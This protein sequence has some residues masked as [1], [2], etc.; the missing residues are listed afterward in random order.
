MGKSFPQL[1]LFSPSLHSFI[2]SFCSPLLV[3]SAQLPPSFIPSSLC[4]IVDE[5]PRRLWLVC[6]LVLQDLPLTLSLSSYSTAHGVVGHSFSS[7]A[8]LAANASLVS[9][10]RKSGRGISPCCHHF[11][12]LFHVLSVPPLSRSSSPY[13]ILY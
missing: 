1:Q 13:N 2:L 11:S 8:H 10:S 9:A 5:T 7:V 4:S 6:Y 12:F 3:A